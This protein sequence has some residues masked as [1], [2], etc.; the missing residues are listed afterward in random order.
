[1][2]TKALEEKEIESKLKDYSEWSYED[3]E[4]IRNFEFR[5]FVEAFGFMAKAA[6]ISETLEHH[7]NWSNVYNRV[8]IRLSTHDAGGVSEKDFTWIE[9]IQTLL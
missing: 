5:N 3:G 1:M 7:P 9:K 2:A 4:L 8:D 6:L